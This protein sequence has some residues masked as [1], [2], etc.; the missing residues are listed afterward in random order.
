[1][2]IENIVVVPDGDPSWNTRP[3]IEAEQPL[4]NATL[5]SQGH[6]VFLSVSKAL[7]LDFNKVAV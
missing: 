3:N 4:Q 2:N 5:S 6:D 1:M 7:S